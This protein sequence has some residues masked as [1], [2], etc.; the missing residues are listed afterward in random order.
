MWHQARHL[1][2]SK[3]HLWRPTATPLTVIIAAWSSY[4]HRVQSGNMLMWGRDLQD[5][6]GA[7]P[8]DVG[9]PGANARVNNSRKDMEVWF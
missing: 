3:L 5:E 6:G 9:L 7:V 4:D 1:G 2:P 8:P